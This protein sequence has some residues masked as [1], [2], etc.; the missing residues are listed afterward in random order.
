MV[1]I[2]IEKPDKI[3]ALHPK[4]LLGRIL[5]LE[6]HNYAKVVTQFGIIKGLIAPNHLNYCMATNTK[7]D[8]IKK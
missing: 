6:N 4:M 8:M 5:S 2:Q 7:L 1:A 3:S